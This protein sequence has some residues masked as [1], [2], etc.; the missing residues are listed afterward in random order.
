MIYDKFYL[1]EDVFI[2][3]FAPEKPKTYIRDALL[4]IPD[5]GYS[6]IC[7]D[8]EGEPIALEFMHKGYSC[9]VLHL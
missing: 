8:R 4:I 1:S 6:E 3:I 2:E 5:G 7:N 9:F